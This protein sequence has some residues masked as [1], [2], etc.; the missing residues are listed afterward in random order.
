MKMEFDSQTVET[1]E[2]GYLV[3][4]EDWSEALGNQIAESEGLVLTALHWDLINYLRDEYLNNA[5][6]Q[7]H[8]ITF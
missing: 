4:I 6:N 2:T 3:N 1:T 8:S 7:L 5:G